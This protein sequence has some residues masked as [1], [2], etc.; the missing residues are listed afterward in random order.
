M[1]NPYSKGNPCL[2]C[3]RTLCGPLPPSFL[4][5]RAIVTPDDNINMTSARVTNPN[6]TTRYQLDENGRFNNYVI[7]PLVFFLKQLYCFFYLA[8]TFNGSTSIF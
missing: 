6:D 4:N 5:L 1:K 8:S 3:F 2:N 7:Y